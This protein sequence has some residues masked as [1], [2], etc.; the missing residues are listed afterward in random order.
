M[1]TISR[2]STRD[3][4]TYAR[5]TH[6]SELHR[7][8]VI[9]TKKNCLPSSLF[10]LKHRNIKV[11]ITDHLWGWSSGDPGIPPDIGPV[12]C[13]TC[14]FNGVIQLGVGT[15]IPKRPPPF[16]GLGC[17]VI[18][19]D[20]IVPHQTNI[21]SRCLSTTEILLNWVLANWKGRYMCNIFIRWL[22]DINWPSCCM[23]TLI[24]W[25]IL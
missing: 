15:C 10:R 4:R 23:Y 7:M 5:L 12:M 25:N 16:A 3:A 24:I 20:H 11:R 13:K 18:N 2:P 6:C 1:N 8:S 14:P 21:R 17:I 19:V 22:R 9:V